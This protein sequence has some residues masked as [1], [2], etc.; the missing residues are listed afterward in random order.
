MPA[1]PKEPPKKRTKKPTPADE[2]NRLIVDKAIQDGKR[3]AES[4]LDIARLFIARGQTD[5]ARRRLQ[6]LLEIHGESDEAAEAREL[7]K[8]CGKGRK[9]G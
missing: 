8:S 4:K 6:E 7:L 9:R 1:A 3:L 2:Q 5:I